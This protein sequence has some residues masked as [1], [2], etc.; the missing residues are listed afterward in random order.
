MWTSLSALENHPELSDLS[1][2]DL[3]SDLSKIPENIRGAVRNNGGGHANHSFFWILSA[4]MVL[5]L[6]MNH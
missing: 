1:I 6:Q 4:P 5:V 3:I 2:F